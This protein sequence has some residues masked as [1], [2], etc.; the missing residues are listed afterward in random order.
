MEAIGI[1]DP[2]KA[3]RMLKM[4]KSGDLLKSV[5]FASVLGRRNILLCVKT[6]AVIF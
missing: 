5:L 6:D 3:E 2:E 4:R 1:H